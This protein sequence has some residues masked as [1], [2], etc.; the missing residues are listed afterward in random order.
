[1]IIINN[2]ILAQ[3]VLYLVILTINRNGSF[4]KPTNA[5]IALASAF[6]LTMLNA[7]QAAAAVVAPVWTQAD[8]VS[9]GALSPG[10][11]GNASSSQYFYQF[12][13]HNDSTMSGDPYGTLPATPVLVDWELPYYRDM[14]ISGI[15][16]ASGW[17]YEIATIGTAN[18][19]TGWSG[20]ADWMTNPLWATSP[21]SAV[22][23]VI[24]WYCDGGEGGAPAA[25]CGINPGDS[26]GDF[27]FYAGYAP[28]DAPYQSSW[29]YVVPRRVGDPPFP[30]QLAPASP[31][32]LGNCNPNNVPEPGTL[33]LLSLGIAAAFGLGRKKRRIEG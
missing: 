4:M 22:T 2:N 25:W 6:T 19:A 10:A 15:Y 29:D 21:F 18:A 33:A 24:H 31:C 13:V 26:I 32:A 16:S 23:E 7:P 17:R 28:T 27:G 8:H 3:I 9:G 5:V 11:S 20:I 30:I 1:L 14:G 12:Q